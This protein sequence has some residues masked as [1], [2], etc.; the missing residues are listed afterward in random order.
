MNKFKRL[1]FSKNPFRLPRIRSGEAAL[2]NDS[3]TWKQDV[4]NG[5]EPLV[6]GIVNNQTIPFVN[7]LKLYDQ[8]NG[9]DGWYSL[10][11]NTDVTFSAT[12]YDDEGGVAGGIVFDVSGN[13]GGF[14]AIIN[15]GVDLT[16]DRFYG[17]PDNNGKI[18]AVTA[19]AHEV[20]ANAAEAPNVLY[21]NEATGKF[22]ITTA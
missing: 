10:I 21:Y 22:Q 5:P 9:N 13:A 19:Y 6:D 17:L 15:S 12:C 4:G 11:E 18:A 3:G 2:W 8:S 7:K 14:R 20:A 1:L 16:S